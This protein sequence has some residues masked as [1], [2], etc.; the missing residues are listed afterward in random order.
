[1]TTFTRQVNRPYLTLYAING[2]LEIYPDRVVVH[3]TNVT[4]KG[5]PDDISRTTETINLEDIADV[6]RFIEDLPID[7]YR[8]LVI[9]PDEHR[10]LFLIY[11]R[12]HRALVSE[13]VHR[14]NQLMEAKHDQA[15]V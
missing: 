12:S 14:L 8:K 6:S 5:A 1:M 13:I 7:P 9:T 3:H 15:T 4:P 10:S 11:R 2:Q